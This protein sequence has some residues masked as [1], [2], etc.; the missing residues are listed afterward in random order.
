M[1]LSVSHSAMPLLVVDYPNSRQFPTI[2]SINRLLIF[3]KRLAIIAHNIQLH[4][5]CSCLSPSPNMVSF[6]STFVQFG[7]LNL[8]TFFMSPSVNVFH[9]YMHFKKISFCAKQNGKLVFVI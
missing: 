8:A 9:E 7:L 3:Q 6:F 2:L 4:K 5:H 1:C